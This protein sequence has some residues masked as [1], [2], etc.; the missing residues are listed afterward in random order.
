MNK[1][2]SSAN[3]RL[4]TESNNQLRLIQKVFSDFLIC[5]TPTVKSQPKNVFEL[6]KYV[7]CFFFLNISESICFPACITFC[8]FNTALCQTQEVNPSI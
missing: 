2:F 8:L 4:K 3:E 1:H 7:I 5:S 6:I